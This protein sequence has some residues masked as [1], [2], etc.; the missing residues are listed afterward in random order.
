MNAPVTSSAFNPQVMLSFA[1]AAWDNMAPA[2]R[3][4]IL[5]DITIDVPGAGRQTLID[6]GS[7]R[8]FCQLP[9]LAQYYAAAWI[10]LGSDKTFREV[11]P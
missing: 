6:D 8:K 1:C 9:R 3:A 7:L 11:K 5:E 10:L 2:A 4:K